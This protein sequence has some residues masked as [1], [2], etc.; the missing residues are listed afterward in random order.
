MRSRERNLT[1]IW[2]APEI[3]HF[4]Q[5]HNTLSERYNSE[6]RVHSLA[7]PLQK[8]QQTRCRDVHIVQRKHWVQ[9]SASTT[10]GIVSEGN[11]G[12]WGLLTSARPPAPA[13]SGPC[14]FP[15]KPVSPAAVENNSPHLKQWEER[16][17]TGCRHLKELKAIGFT[18]EG[19][20]ESWQLLVWGFF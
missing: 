7:A 12:M 3:Q 9:S 10:A 14:L 19:R 18:L 11:W 4:L 15:S 17:D 20:E 16:T 8:G 13:A 6:H 1:P 2:R 5:I